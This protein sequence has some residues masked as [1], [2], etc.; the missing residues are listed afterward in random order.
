MTRRSCLSMIV[1]MVVRAAVADGGV[2]VD[3]AVVHGS[4]LTLLMQPAEARVGAARFTLL[5]APDGEA[6]VQM[7]RDGARS[8]SR[9]LTESG[10]PGRHA[11][12]TFERAGAC[13]VAVMVDGERVLAA[14]IMVGSAEPGWLSRL[15]WIFSWV[16]LLAL[17][18]LR[19]WRVRRVHWSA[20]HDAFTIQ[21]ARP[22]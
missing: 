9:L 13:T 4:R 17:V 7:E 11:D 10:R 6:L 3:S 12:V 16:P 14:S 5:G 18:A 1:L 15:P 2:P 22:S 21:R 19:A 8:S 20:R